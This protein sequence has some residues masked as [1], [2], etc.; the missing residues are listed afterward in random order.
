MNHVELE[1]LRTIR[2]GV[3]V[4]YSFLLHW[5]RRVNL[6][7][8]ARNLGT[9][10]RSPRPASLQIA[11]DGD[12]RLVKSIDESG[13]MRLR[14]YKT[15]S[16]YQRTISAIAAAPLPREADSDP[17]LQT[18]FHLASV[19]DSI[20]GLAAECLDR[21]YTLLLS[22]LY[23]ETGPNDPLLDISFP[24]TEAGL[25]GWMAAVAGDFSYVFR[26]GS[27]LEQYSGTLARGFRRTADIELYLPPLDRKDWKQREVLMEQADLR[28]NDA[29][30]IFAGWPQE[31]V[32]DNM[33]LLAAFAAIDRTGPAFS[34]TV[35]HRS[36]ADESGASLM[37]EI[38]GHYL[39]AWFD[40]PGDRH[41]SYRAAYGEIAL[42]VQRVLRAEVP[43]LWFGNRE[44][45]AK[46]PESIAILVYKCSR[47]FLGKTRT[48]LTYEFQSP[49][50]MRRFYKTAAAAL[51]SELE[52]IHANLEGSAEAN[53]YAP[54]YAA[55][56]VKA[57]QDRGRCLDRL[58]AAESTIIEC[59]IEFGL[60]GSEVRGRIAA[61]PEDAAEIA[62]GYA[63]AFARTL[64]Y[65]VKR[66]HPTLD[67]SGLALPLLMEASSALSGV[68]H[69]EAGVYSISRMQSQNGT[70]RFFANS[71]EIFSDPA[72]LSNRQ[73]IA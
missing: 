69:G 45:Y 28:S 73:Q 66:I 11:V 67:C 50:S 43:R 34:S 17:V 12:F 22:R 60:L 44:R 13:L 56:L 27:D 4:D 16:R 47:P 63:E 72:H 9:P 21:Q 32:A 52:R 25:E 46:L 31:H 18:V 23:D 20:Y 40:A 33:L 39:T 57:V 55:K 53:F 41:A 6:H 58:M 38:P 61:D 15:A 35:A 71:P 2:I 5:V 7:E 19:R 65:R 59:F 8:V 49:A 68:M 54:K 64:H 3:R 10:L 1:D 37:R 42:A 51:P 70:V 24:N 62:A 29:G 26:P 30:Q 48:E 36:I 14:V